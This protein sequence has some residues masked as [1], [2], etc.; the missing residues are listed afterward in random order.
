MPI[1]RLVRP[2]VARLAGVLVV[3]AVGLQTPVPAQAARLG[4]MSVQLERGQPLRAEVEIEDATSETLAAEPAIVSPETYRDLGLTFPAPLRGARV[5]MERREADGRP[6]IRIVGRTPTEAP[7][8][9][10]VMS[11]STPAGRHLRSYRLDLDASAAPGPA[12]AAVPPPPAPVADSAA[13]A[14]EPPLPTT[15]LAPQPMTPEPARMVPPRDVPRVEA[16]PSAPAVVALPSTAEPSPS[17]AQP[18]SAPSVP[19][20]ARGA[21]A[22]GPLPATLSPPAAA[23]TASPIT[24]PSIT[25][26]P[27]E[28]QAA[29]PA[30][31]T[32]ARGD[33]AASIANRVRPADVTEAQAAMALY[34]NNP[35]AF[36]G[37]VSRPRP[38]ATVRIPSPE[39]MRALPA[40]IAEQALRG[41]GASLA[42]AAPAGTSA[43]ARIAVAERGDHLQLSAG[44]TGRGK[45]AD[46]R[47]GSAA[48][49]AIAYD[50]AMA[51][52]RSRITQLESIVDGLKRLI[53][54]RDK[55]IAALSSEL[56][57]AGV[58]VAPASTPVGEM[59]VPSAAGPSMPSPV[60]GAPS[61]AAPPVPPTAQPP[62]PMASAAPASDAAP[63]LGAAAATM[64]P[65]PTR[66]LPA[67]IP[68]PEPDPWYMDPM[69]LGGAGVGVLL[70]VLL[71]A[72][73]RGGKGKGKAR[74]GKGSGRF[75]AAR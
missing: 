27:V 71:A 43:P 14:A 37:S 25:T 2:A 69:V 41:Q 68:E 62:A 47:G 51:E 46:A 32:I 40:P 50:A 30:T 8:L 12:R 31:L 26:R 18:P 11:L 16:L 38:G 36:D 58:A 59:P 53:D 9:I 60:A 21:S 7:E 20:S 4:A 24:T 13:A 64:L 33:T 72:R 65:A 57:A 23:A 73:M 5:T 52:A 49:R 28:S 17:P 19:P 63:P 54:E 75:A 55:Q 34:R 45:Q 29:E 6:V 3:L 42:A 15:R 48:N 61:A 74:R 44:G 70:L 56:R 39:Q 35:S 10:V 66:R 22:P 1:D 67:P